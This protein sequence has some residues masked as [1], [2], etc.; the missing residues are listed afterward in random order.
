LSNLDEF[1]KARFDKDML[2]VLHSMGSHGPAYY[3]RYPQEFE[4][5]YP[6]VKPINLTSVAMKKSITPT[7]I[8]SSTRIIF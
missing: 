2:I 4:V 3:K 8:V 7:T 6:F 5:F 1:I